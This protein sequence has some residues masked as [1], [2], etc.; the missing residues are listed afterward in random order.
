MGKKD[1]RI[2]EFQNELKR[3][4][5]LRISDIETLFQVSESTA[6]RMCAELELSGC[7]VR[8]FGGI[9][10]LPEQYKET[11]QT[12]SFDL[13]TEQYSE[14]KRRIGAYAAGLVEPGDTI[15]LSGG[16][17][18]YQFA[19][20]LAKLLSEKG[21]PDLN[22]M[23]NSV[24]NAEILSTVTRVILTGGEYRARRRDTAGLVGEKSINNARFSKS[25]IGLDGIDI[26]DGLMTWDIE[27]A[28]ID[29][30]TIKRSDYVYLLTDSSKFKKRTFIN[31]E[32]LA[33]EYTIITDSSLPE[34]IQENA[35][36]NGQSIIVV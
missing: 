30:L 27:T 18:V 26:S 2:T 5:S 21:I 10:Y 24:A 20:H 14:E 6:R 13:L 12:Y 36:R 8:T 15:F 7:A 3:Q 32:E 35:A 16:T 9:Q 11:Y 23:T 22:I 4:K 25:F 28:R 19:S 34:E 31:Y 29:Q 1:K 33:P 17:T